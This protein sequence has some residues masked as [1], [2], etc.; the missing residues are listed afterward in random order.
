MYSIHWLFYVTLAPEEKYP[1]FFFGLGKLNTCVFS[2]YGNIRPLRAMLGLFTPYILSAKN[3]VII[4]LGFPLLRLNSLIFY[5]IA[6][7]PGVGG[8]SLI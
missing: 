1:A 5:T 6:P 7:S 2:S 4:L 8:K 3:E